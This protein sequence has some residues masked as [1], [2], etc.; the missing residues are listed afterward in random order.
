MKDLKDLLEKFI[1]KFVIVIVY[2]E[3]KYND[4]IKKVVVE[5]GY[6]MGFIIE[7]GYVDKDDSCVLLNRICIDYIYKFFDI[8]K[9][10][11]NLCK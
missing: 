7:R 9:V 8:K 10:L 11:E 2:L 4:D 1:G 5:V 6:F 3:G